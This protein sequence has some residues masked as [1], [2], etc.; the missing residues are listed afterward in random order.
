VT[1]WR[2]VTE[3]IKQ[4]AEQ[5]Q[6]REIGF[7]R[8][9]AR[10]TASDLSEA[11]IDVV[12]VGQGY[13]DMSPACKRLEELVL[14]RRLKH[15]G[16]PVLRWNIDCCSVSADPAGNIKP[17]KPERNKSSKRI[18]GVVASAMAV[19]RAMSAEAYNPCVV[20]A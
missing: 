12:D 8:Y 14:S 20:F 6:I 19:G 1:D 16:N 4:L 10:D 7:D 17:V 15:S 11:G 5:F 9:G 18:D 3:R 13:L 2:F